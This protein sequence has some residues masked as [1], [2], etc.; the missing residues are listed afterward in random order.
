MSAWIDLQVFEANRSYFL[1][2]AAVRVNLVKERE[3]AYIE[4]GNNYETLDELTDGSGGLDYAHTWRDDYKADAVVLIT[5]WPGTSISGLAKQMREYHI[6]DDIF[7]SFE[8]FAFAVVDAG[9]FETAEFTFAHELG[10][11]LGAQHNKDASGVTPGAVPASSYGHYDETPGVA[12][13]PG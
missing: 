4:D 7:K 10:H 6:P 8:P 11:V 12:A 5:Y 2:N 3:I 9:G 1:S 13:T